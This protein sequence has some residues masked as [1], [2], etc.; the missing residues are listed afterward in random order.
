MG[1]PITMSLTGALVILLF[2]IIL[3][4]MMAASVLRK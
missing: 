1:E 4:M 2:G 3:G